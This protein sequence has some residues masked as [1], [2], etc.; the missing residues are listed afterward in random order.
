LRLFRR[1]AVL[2]V[3]LPLL[4]A[5]AAAP[6]ASTPTLVATADVSLALAATESAATPSVTVTALPPVPVEPTAP[7][8]RTPSPTPTLTPSAT[9][10]ATET[11]TPTETATPTVTP[12]ETGT[13][14]PTAS[15]TLPPQSVLPRPSV[16]GGYLNT[17]RLVT[18]YG[19]PLGWGLGVL[20]ES[21]RDEMFRELRNLTGYYQSL[22]TDGRVAV[23]TFHMVTSVANAYPPDYRHHVDRGVI[24][25]W[26]DY[27]NANGAA[28]IID[29]QPG[30]ADIMAEF[31][32][33]RDFLYYP[34]VHL[35]IDP[36]YAMNEEQ[37]PLQQIGQVSAETINAL[38]AELSQIAGEIGVN[39]VL[40][41]H[42]FK[43]SMIID[44]ANI[45]NF[46]QVEVV[47]DMDGYGSPG[48]KLR[49]Y[50]QYAAEPGKDY[51]G[52]KLFFRD[53]WDNPLL[54][55]E[56][57]LGLQPIPALIVYQ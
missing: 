31:N 22:S 47:I 15:P 3:L 48:P 14:T 9:P 24:A 51:L 23:P 10:T 54:T 16:A 32:R 46:P 43:D 6:A 44:K 4:S 13:P 11:P 57:V 25:N 29:I 8:T 53:I 26:I 30:R 12:T 38:Q 52:I 40:I 42:Q 1:L 45:Q 2:L 5:C 39:R 33:I 41:V 27:A 21:P 17:V 49:N 7:P 50:F 28:V 55:P 19:S 56:E 20:G 18:Y 35:A 37:V 36:E 34:H